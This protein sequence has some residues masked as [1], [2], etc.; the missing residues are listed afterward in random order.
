MS[1]TT[2][3]Y[4]LP[5]EAWD[6]SLAQVLKDTNERPLNV[7]SLMAHNPLLLK[8]WWNFRNYSVNGGELGRRQ[9]ELVILRVA[10]HMRAWYE[11]GSHVDRSLACGLSLTEIERV[12]QG[13]RAEG[14]SDND[15]VLLDAV[16]ELIADHGLGETCLQQLSEHY[17]VPQILDIMAIHGMYVILACMI[18]TW[19]LELDDHVQTA[20]PATVTPAAFEQLLAP[21]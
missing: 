3:V 21:S 5:I 2:N 10:V 14:W 6:S 11:W 19:G 1:H 13:G 8:A 9:A 15:S 20:L 18:N 4:P 7:H 12:A 16:D 17:S